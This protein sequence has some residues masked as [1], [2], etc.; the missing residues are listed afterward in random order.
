MTLCKRGMHV[1]YCIDGPHKKLKHM[2]IGLEALTVDSAKQKK[3]TRRV[4]CK[5]N[6]L[7]YSVL[8]SGSR[9]AKANALILLQTN[10]K[11]N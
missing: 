5:G 2:L 7:Q 10:C 11:V 3:K 1:A 6:R 4:Q 9:T 8:P